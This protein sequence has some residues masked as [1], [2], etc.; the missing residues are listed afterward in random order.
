ND[1]FWSQ[2]EGWRLNRRQYL[3]EAL[4]SEISYTHPID[5][6][7]LEVRFGADGTTQ[8]GLFAPRTGY[9]KDLPDNPEPFVY[10]TFGE[11]RYTLS[12]KYLLRRVAKLQAAVGT[13]ARLDDLGDNMEGDNAVNGNPRHHV[14][15]PIQYL[16]GALY[17]EGFY[18]YSERLGFHLGS[19]YDIHTR[20]ARFGGVISPKAALVFTPVPGHTVKAVVQ[21]S[22]NNG[23]ADNYEYNSTNFDDSGKVS[24]GDRL[25]K[26]NTPPNNLLDI[27]RGV[28]S[29]DELHTLRPERNYSFELLSLHTFGD[30]LTVQP[31]VSYNYVKD[32]FAWSQPLLHVV[33]AGDYRF[34]NVDF[35]T[36]L[37]LSKVTLG[38]NHAWQVP[39][40]TDPSASAIRFTRAYYDTNEVWYDSTLVNGSWQYRPVP[41]ASRMDTV[42]LNSVIDQITRD[43]E[44]FLNLSTHISKFQ[45]DYSPWPWLGLHTDARVFWG[46]KGR[47]SLYAADDKRNFNSLG[48]ANDAMTKWNASA[49]FRLPGGLRVSLHVYD[50]LGVDNGPEKDNTLAIHTL[51]WHQMADLAHKDLYSVDQRSYL[52]RVE[53]SL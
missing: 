5:E 35:E 18:R 31:S 3:T 28:P 43:G 30:I 15:T 17:A 49:H 42:E 36:S 19:R 16:N 4:M 27:Q 20:T 52:L 39:V 53:K 22:S 46:L 23:T 34:V 47:D 26:P 9:E 6:D 10:E 25:S 2:T 21:S 41:S 11:R 45:A 13:E 38:F 48:I 8:R 37:R 44:N 33:N 51:R 29:L 1:P 40:D 14:I 50:I 7:E 12:S 24:S 32:L